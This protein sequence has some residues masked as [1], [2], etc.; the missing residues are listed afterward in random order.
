M[1][2]KKDLKV[3]IAEDD[4]IASQ[5]LEEFLGDYFRDII[6]ANDGLEA[7]K[8]YK[9]ENPDIIITDISMPKL[10]GLEFV[11]AIREE[12]REIPVIVTTAFSTNEYLLRAV[13]LGLLKYL[14]KPINEDDLIQALNLYFEI[15]NI[16]DKNIYNIEKNITYDLLNQTLVKDN[17]VIKLR[18]KEIL[19]LELLIRNKNRY[20]TYIEIENYVWKDMPMSADA[21]KTLVKRLRAII[22]NE[23]ILNLSGTGYKIE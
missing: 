23:H 8:L 3:L 4:L 14:I 2:E 11:K 18:T 16:E 7:L 1:M 5:N 9:E 21:L 6:I 13:E 10:D 20:V 17:E 19:F 12:N 15:L 22:G